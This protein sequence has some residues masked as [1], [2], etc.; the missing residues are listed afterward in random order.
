MRANKQIVNGIRV[1]S[2]HSADCKHHTD[3][4]Y[5]SCTC[6][7][8]L[9]WQQDGKQMRASTGE[10]SKERA[11]DAARDKDLELRGEAPKVVRVGSTVHAAVDD[12]LKYRTAENKGNAKAAL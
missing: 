10:R 5:L 3:A 4:T 8:W 11:E 9:Q 6:T 1:Y 7:K 2:R 12:W